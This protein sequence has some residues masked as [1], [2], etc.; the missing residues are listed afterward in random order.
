ML[1]CAMCGVWGGVGGK[2]E[3]L[4][5]FVSVVRQEVFYLG[6]T[7]DEFLD[8][9]QRAHLARGMQ[10]R[11]GRDAVHQVRRL[12]VARQQLLCGWR[13]KRM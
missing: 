10:R 11:R 5:P 6:A 8:D 12:G 9:G 2:R 4:R 7:G 3:L 1:I 13:G